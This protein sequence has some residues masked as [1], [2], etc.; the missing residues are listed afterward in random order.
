ME[1]K[2]EKVC[3]KCTEATIKVYNTNLRRLYKMYSGKKVKTLKDVPETP[4]WLMSAKLEEAYNKFPFNIR[5]HLS[6]SAFIGTKAYGLKPSNKWNKLMLRD[7]KQYED[8]RSKNK[9]SEY[10][11]KNIPKNGMKDLTKAIK[12]YKSQIRRTLEGKPTLAGLYKYQLF[13]A[14]KFMTSDTPLRNDLPTLNVEAEKDNYLKKKKNTYTI[15]MTNFKNSSRI[16]PREIKLSR[17]NSMEMKRFLK[18]RSE[19]VDHDFL[20]SLKNGKPMSKKAFSQSLIKLTTDLLGRRIGSRLL[21]IIF[22]TKNE[23]L[24][25]KADKVSNQMLHTTKQT[26]EYVR[27]K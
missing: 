22:A 8:N 1:K 12:L 10:E 17:A 6:S 25:S 7:A 4:K 20:F 23:E 16:G 26:R 14:L 18:Y 24:L 15:V 21:R 11:E 3:T 2:L 27:K 9:K 19:L 5:R 13:L